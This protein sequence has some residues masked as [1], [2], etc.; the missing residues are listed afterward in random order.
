MRQAPSTHAPPHEPLRPRHWFGAIG[1][2]GAWILHLIAVY[3]LVAIRCEASGGYTVF[4]IGVVAVT[5]AAVAIAAAAGWT[6][7]R[8]IA[9]AAARP[10]LTAIAR[11]AEHRTQVL[12]LIGLTQ[13]L[14][15]IPLIIVET[16]PMLIAPLCA[17][18]V[19]G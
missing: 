7:Y 16:F 4:V 8:E 5:L 19:T 10:I 6:A 12:G 17:A 18:A 2:G 3:A 9:R 15:F 14:I 11:P 13:A 1:A